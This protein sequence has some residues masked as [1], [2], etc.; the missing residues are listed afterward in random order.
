MLLSGVAAPRREAIRQLHSTI[1]GF[2]NPQFTP[3]RR[4]LA[5][6][7]RGLAPLGGG[8]PFEWGSVA[9]GLEHCF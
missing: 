5:S 3:Q 6:Q 7:R 4:G 2:G 8:E 9:A 1:T